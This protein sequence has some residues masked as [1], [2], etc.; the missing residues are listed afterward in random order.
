[1][2]QNKK[3]NTKEICMFNIASGMKKNLSNLLTLS[4]PDDVPDDQHALKG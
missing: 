1:M 4:V 3:N 2:F